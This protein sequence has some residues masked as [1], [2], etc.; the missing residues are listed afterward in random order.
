MIRETF[1]PEISRWVCPICGTPT[2]KREK[3]NIKDS[4]DLKTYNK[5]KQREHRKKWPIEL[6]PGDRKKGACYLG[7]KPRVDTGKE[8]KE[9]NKELVRLGLMKGYETQGRIG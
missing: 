2:P 3:R 4:E 8:R 9:V 7:H 5:V 6:R 1:N